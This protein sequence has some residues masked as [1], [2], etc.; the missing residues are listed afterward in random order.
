MEKNAGSFNV[1]SVLSAEYANPILDCL[2]KSKIELHSLLEPY[3]D[4]EI[5][6]DIK[7]GFR[8]LIDGERVKCFDC[9]FKPVYTNC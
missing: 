9:C 4:M 8:I 6:F 5:G 1:V 2:F 7:D 3:L